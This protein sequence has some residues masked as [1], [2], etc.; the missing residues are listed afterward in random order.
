MVLFL[1]KS[2]H[3][4]LGTIRSSN[5]C[6]E[7][8]QYSSPEET[9]VCNLGSIGLPAFVFSPT[10]FDFQE[11]HKVTKILTRN[12]NTIIDR[13]SYPTASG[14]LSNQHHRPIGIGVQG[15]ADVFIAMQ[16]PFESSAA[17]LLNV[18]IFETIYHAALEASCELAAEFG[19]YDTWMGSPAQL[20]ELQYDLWGVTPGSMW[21][22]APLRQ[23]IAI[24][25]LRNSL[26]V[27]PMPTATTS[28]LLGY[29][30]GFEPY[31]KQV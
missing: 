30:D 6:T 5:L 24:S 2:N 18:A 12:L 16:M 20:G 17:A 28:I 14:K 29:N 7:V 25:G 19:P 15:L 21:D 27:A 31:T 3:R 11:L 13:T 26:L 9:A 22:W 1:A 10:E 4:H 23:S 8:L